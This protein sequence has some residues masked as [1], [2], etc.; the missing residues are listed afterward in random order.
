MGRL[1]TAYHACAKRIEA[2]E[3]KRRAEYKRSRGFFIPEHGGGDED[4]DNNNEEEA[5]EIQDDVIGH[6]GIGCSRG[7]EEKMKK[8]MFACNVD[9][10]AVIMTA[11][12]F[13]CV[14]SVTGMIDTAGAAYTGGITRI[15]THV[16]SLLI[17]L[18]IIYQLILFTR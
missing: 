10:S 4:D 5:E 3:R 16:I 8:T 2:E 17:K 1:T 13:S 15:D 7:Q 6:V 9:V 14:F 18:L 12:L 11:L